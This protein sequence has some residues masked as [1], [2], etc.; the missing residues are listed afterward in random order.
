MS[1]IKINIFSSLEPFISKT[2][3]M[4]FNDTKIV[5]G[6]LTVQ[7]YIQLHLLYLLNKH[8]HLIIL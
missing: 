5:P 6:H 3:Y 1:R 4:Y 7:Q 2:I 8:V